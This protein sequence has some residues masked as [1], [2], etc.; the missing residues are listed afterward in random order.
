MTQDLGESVRPAQVCR[1]LL[2]ALEAAE[3]RRRNRKRDQTP[4]GIGLAIKRRL[5]E[6]AVREDPEPETFEAWLLQCAISIE[7]R[8]QSPGAVAAMARSIFE[9]WCMVHSLENFR[10]WLERG[11]PSDDAFEKSENRHTDKTRW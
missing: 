2:D 7:D 9:E 8:P 11:A 10:D 6:Q 1:G 4:D 5:L 3:G